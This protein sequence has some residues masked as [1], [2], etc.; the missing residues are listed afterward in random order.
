VRDL[1][2]ELE[3]VP[4]VGATVI[5]HSGYCQIS[6]RRV[7]VTNTRCRTGTFSLEREI[8]AFRPDKRKKKID[9]D[10][11]F[12]YLLAESIQGHVFIRY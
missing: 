1:F 12:Q 11:A 7:C 8:I 9:I 10:H 6:S 4:V 3:V 5:R 2:L